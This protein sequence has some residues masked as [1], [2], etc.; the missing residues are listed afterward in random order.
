MRLIIQATKGKVPGKIK[1]VFIDF[2][3]SSNV[4]SFTQ[5]TNIKNDLFSLTEGL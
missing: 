2:N 1:S 3:Y 4:C 5:A